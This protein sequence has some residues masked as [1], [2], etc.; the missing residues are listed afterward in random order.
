MGDIFIEIMEKGILCDRRMARINY[1]L[2]FLLQNNGSS[3]ISLKGIEVAVS[4]CQKT[5]FSILITF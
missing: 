2:S 3:V 5:N 1:H 4:L